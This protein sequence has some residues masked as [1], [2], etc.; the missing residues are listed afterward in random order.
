MKTAISV[1]IKFFVTV[2]IMFFMVSS[3][4]STETVINYIC[5]EF[6]RFRVD[7]FPVQKRLFLYGDFL[8][9]GFFI[10]FSDCLLQNFILSF[11]C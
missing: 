3:F 7:A 6:I 2:N 9:Y 5:V 8:E 4:L 10:L 11:L 1:I